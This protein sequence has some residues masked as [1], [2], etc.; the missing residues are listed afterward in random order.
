MS[1]EILPQ[2]LYIIH[3]YDV[4]ECEKIREYNLLGCA[5]YESAYGLNKFDILVSDIN[6][7]AFASKQ[8]AWLKV[9]LKLIALSEWVESELRHAKN[10][11]Q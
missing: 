4:V 3:N 5:R 11:Q 9:Q 6:S 2:K 10:M 1:Q 7:I 8:K